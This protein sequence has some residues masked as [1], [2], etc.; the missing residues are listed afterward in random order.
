MASENPW[1]TRA[2]GLTA[3]RLLLA[4]LLAWA[5]VAGAHPLSGILFWIAV[6]S[7]FGDGWVA[8]K[9]GEESPLG[10]LVDHAVDATFVTTG[11]AALASLGA[12]PSLLPPVIALAFLQYALD[13]RWLAGRTLRASAIGRWNG[14]G[15]YV[16]I[17]IP[18]TR[19]LLTL[20]WPPAILVFAVGW[21]LIATSA[22][23][24]IDR[25]VVL[26]RALRDI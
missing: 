26:R 3:L 22:V 16:A 8:R 20:S 23:S 6:A 9:Y 11:V 10:G 21:L 13:S 24:M 12:L 4:P 2:N 5:V 1:I 7:D 15:Y 25:A 19:D 17:G 18:V 14:I